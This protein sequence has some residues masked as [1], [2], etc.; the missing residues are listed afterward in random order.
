M[1]SVKYTGVKI[2]QQRE[3]EEIYQ[4]NRDNETEEADGAA[5]DLHDEDLDEERGV[6][7]VGEGGP[8]AHLAHADAAHQVSQPRGDPGPEHRISGE[9]I[10]SKQI[11][12][13]R[14]DNGSLS[15]RLEKE[16]NTVS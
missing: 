15:V 16:S 11:P 12:T 6:G 4:K 2:L 1:K 7:G 13:T 14:L 5:E 3:R 9:I 8:G 10:T